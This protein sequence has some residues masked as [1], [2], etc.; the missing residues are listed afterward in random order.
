MLPLIHLYVVLAVTLAAYG[1]V[2][3]ERGRGRRV[4]R[5]VAG[6]LELTYAAVDPFGLAGKLAD[7][8]PVAGAARLVVSD[9]VYGARGDRYLYIFTAE[10]TIGAIRMKKRLRLVALYCE[11]V[12]PHA[13]AAV[14]QA[15]AVELGPAGKE[16]EDQYRVLAR[17]WLFPVPSPSGEG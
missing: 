15:C 7:R 13:P 9:L 2:R 1:F 8:F 16:W 6:E 10:C 17:G 5:G 3:W 4:L 12:D 11:P 14:S